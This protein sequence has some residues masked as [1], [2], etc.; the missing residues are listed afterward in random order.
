MQPSFWSNPPEIETRVAFD[1]GYVL[2]PNDF[3]IDPAKTPSNTF[4]DVVN[5]D[6][7]EDRREDMAYALCCSANDVLFQGAQ[8][9]AYERRDTKEDHRA[10]QLSQDIC[11]TFMF[12]TGGAGD[13]DPC[14]NQ[15]KCG[16]LK[17]DVKAMTGSSMCAALCGKEI[18]AVD[19]VGRA[20]CERRCELAAVRTERVKHK[21]QLKVRVWVQPDERMSSGNRGGT[22]ETRCGVCGTH[23]DA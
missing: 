21:S 20:N 17:D 19:L 4:K 2:L 23:C 13:C 12:N 8:R 9:K 3:E 11:V 22:Y 6:S 14:T 1:A 18:P 16:G 7:H 5:W 15:E 10:S